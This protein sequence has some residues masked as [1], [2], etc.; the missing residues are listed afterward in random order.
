METL[1]DPYTFVLLLWPQHLLQTLHF[2]TGLWLHRLFSSA[3]VQAP[4]SSSG[5]TSSPQRGPS[6]S[7]LRIRRSPRPHILHHPGARRRKW[8]EA[9]WHQGR[10][11]KRHNFHSKAFRLA[12]PGATSSTSHYAV[13]PGAHNLPKYLYYLHLHIQIPLLSVWD[14][15][16]SPWCTVALWDIGEALVNELNSHLFMYPLVEWNVGFMNYH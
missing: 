6:V 5:H 7:F 3:P 9:I 1:I 12:R 16:L 4:H 13:R 10:S 11:R 8:R 15:I 2:Q 14:Y